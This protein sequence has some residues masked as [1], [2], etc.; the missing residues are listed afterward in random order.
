MD[1]HS[2]SR[3]AD[4]VEVERARVEGESDEEPGGEES[5]ASAAA[6]EGRRKEREL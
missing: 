2:R 1:W 3:L 6:A 4:E 5:G